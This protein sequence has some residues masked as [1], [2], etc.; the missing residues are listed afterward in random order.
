MIVIDFPSSLFILILPLWLSIILF[1]IDNPIPWPP[2]F[3]YLEAGI[4]DAVILDIMLPKIDGIT[5]L[6]TVRNN[7]N[8]Y[9]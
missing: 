8:K 2:V 7:N 3:D 5:V 1:A 9:L 6:R 4:Y